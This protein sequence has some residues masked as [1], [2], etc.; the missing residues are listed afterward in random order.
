MD[1]NLASQPVRYTGEHIANTIAHHGQLRPA[2]G[3][4]HIQVL[5]AN[6]THPEWV[7]GSGWTYNHAPM[8]AYWNGRF[9]LEYLSNPV[10]EHGL[11]GQTLLV[12]SADGIHWDRPAVVFPI[13]RVPD[14]VYQGPVPLPPGSD[15]VM[16]QRMGFYVA[17]DGRLLVLGFYGVCPTTAVMPNDGRGI[18][19]VV[20][21]VYADG[22]WGPIYFVRYNRH[23]GWNEGNT[24]YPYYQSAP[25]AGFV[26]ACEALLADR[27]VTLQWWE[28]DRSSDRFYAVAGYKGLSYYH[29][30]DGRVVGLW[31]WSKAAISEDEG[32]SWSLVADVP[33]LIMAGAKIWGQRTS[34]G[35][36]ALVYNPTPSGQH[37]WP[38]AVVT[39]DDGL[40]FDDM[41]LVNGEVP[42]RR[43]AGA[44]K[45]LGQNYVR[46]IVEGN[47][48]PPDGALWIA[49]SMNKEDI[50]VSRI[51]VPIRGRVDEPV[52]D[53]FEDVQLGGV[54]GDWNV[55]SS[56]WAGVSVVARPG[57]QGQQLE[58]RD[59]DPYDYALA[60]RV[61]P[62]STAVAVTLHVMSGQ[63]DTG[64]LEVEIVDCR[65]VSPV[66]VILDAD[67]WIKARQGG[68][69]HSVQPYLPDRWYEICIALDAVAH[70]F[71]LSI[72]GEVVAKGLGCMAPV[73]SVERLVLRTGP[74]RRE[75]TQDT[76]IDALPDLP[77]AD[78][79]VAL[80]VYWID[81]VATGA[82]QLVAG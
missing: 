59:Q 3:V 4:Q 44:H 1:R 62:E 66:R 41:L 9:Y 75:P 77:D 25:D 29:L 43:F 38:L 73:G 67:G 49:Y 16:H 19:R 70:R 48:T 55:Y 34:D 65:G 71:D 76:D 50:W 28:E 69:T 31:N 14:G 80:A 79:P 12:T 30:P 32:Q 82:H 10:S 23:A 42:P 33:S 2:V 68:R 47:G 72:D 5:R 57:A 8:L 64:R 45:D 7:E 58:L 74:R 36:Y 26:R 63:N 13:Y 27:L 37:R 56:A 35:R 39:A 6:R 46:G 21:E 78:E 81:R 40:S 60:E 22:S 17:P 18:G 61:F 52:A 54:I 53:T 15:A 24:H 20:R 51:P 11:P